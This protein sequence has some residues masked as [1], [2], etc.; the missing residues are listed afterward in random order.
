MR[1]RKTK[2]VE[3]KLEK[4]GEYLIFEGQLFKG[5]WS[6]VFTKKG[7]IFL[8]LG[9]GKGQFIVNQ[10]LKNTDKNYIGAEGQPTVALRA[11][12]KASTVKL[13][14]LKF[15]TGFIN[16]ITDYFE[17]DELSG[18]YLNFS[19]PWPKERHSKR[20]LTH[21]KYLEGYISIVKPGS[22]LEFKTDN[23]P[24]FEFTL[25]Q[26][27]QI[28]L[29]PEEVTRHLHETNYQSKEITTE[30][31]DKFKKSGKNINYLKVKLK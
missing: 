13:D 12:E 2:N 28:G 16:N 23:Q 18:I 14:N 15:M 20:R 24:L 7:E 9:C 1:Q 8:E 5:S 10:A 25:E 22:Y 19:D 4:L 29:I 17:E 6:K 31:E 30:Y 11:I 21:N 3:E 26:I 27:Y